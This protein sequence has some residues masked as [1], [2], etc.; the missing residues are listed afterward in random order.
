MA[1]GLLLLVLA[2]R[3]GLPLNPESSLLF[4]A[5]S[6][7]DASVA[8]KPLGA[9]TRVTTSIDLNLRAEPAEDAEIITILGLGVALEVTGPSVNGWVPVTEPNSRQAGFVSDRFVTLVTE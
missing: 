5:Q 1:V 2:I 7:D 3:V 4:T 8:A 6:A 9:G